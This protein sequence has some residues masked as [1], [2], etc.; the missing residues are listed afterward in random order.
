M[1]PSHPLIIVSCSTIFVVNLNHVSVGAVG[2]APQH[3]IIDLQIERGLANFDLSQHILLLL[4]RLSCSN[5]F[6]LTDHLRWCLLLVFIQRVI[7]LVVVV[8]LVGI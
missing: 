7:L 3:V 4:L 1:G 2:V 8:L 5:L 6:L